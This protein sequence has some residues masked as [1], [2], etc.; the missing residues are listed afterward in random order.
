[1]KITIASMS[2]QGDRA[3]NQ[4]QTG[5][6]IG[7]RSACFVVCDG[8]AGFPGGDVAADIARNS[9]MDAFDGNAHLN[10]QSIRNYVNHANHS[11][12]Q[13]Q[14]A[15]REHS[16][17]GTTLVSLFIDRDFELAYW[18]H[19]G[20]SRLYLFRRGY[21]YHV[22]TDHSLVQQMKDAGHQ[23][24]GINNNLLYFA[25]GMGDEQ[26]DVSYSDVVEIEDGDAFLLCTDGFWHG[27]AQE[28]MQQS[29]HM[30]N[31]PEEWMTLMQQ[32][33]KNGQLDNDQQ[34][35]FSALAVWVGSPQDITL[36]HSL[37]EMAQFSP[38]RD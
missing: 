30:V 37:S 32:I 26:R 35:N 9:L 4:D 10:A 6:V 19:A 7:E 28:Q 36:L 2:N 20:D 33:I 23:T 31:T 8:V 17:M 15:C 22:T 25:L 21:L 18:A 38:L 27:V 29:L 16:R 5:D 14:K 13:Q 1:M 11:I 12:R 34:D 24:E 3:S